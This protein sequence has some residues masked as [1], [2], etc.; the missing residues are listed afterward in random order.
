MTRAIGA[1]FQNREITGAEIGTSSGRNANTLL[2][3][4]NIKKLYLID[5]YEYGLH[6]MI[7]AKKVLSRFGDK[8]IFIRKMSSD[9]V[10][11]IPD[12]LDFI[13]IDGPHDYEN[14][15]NDIRLYYNKVKSGGV[16]GGHDFSPNFPGV[17]KTVNEFVKEKGLKLYGEES[18][19]IKKGDWW[20]IK[21]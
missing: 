8:P 3:F 10:D 12:N 5:P 13:Y 6:R 18:L 1:K 4:L 16:F 14:V 9:A 2:S 17:I 20:I 11:D 21:P 7:N 15:K 19:D